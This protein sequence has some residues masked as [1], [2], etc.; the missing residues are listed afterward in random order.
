MAIGVTIKV[1]Q[2][3][4][5]AMAAHVGKT[6]D[7]IRKNVAGAI[8]DCA[9]RQKTNISSLI[10][11]NVNIKKKDVDEHIF[12]TRASPKQLSAQVTLAKTER[13]A[14]KDFG[15]R[16]TKKGVTYKI[17][18]SAAAMALMKSRGGSN[19]SGASR[20]VTDKKG[21]KRFTREPVVQE[22]V[23]GRIPNAFGPNIPRLG[24]N[25]FRRLLRG[26]LP[27]VKLHGPSAWGVF[28]RLGLRKQIKKDAQAY[29]NDRLQRR[30]L[31]QK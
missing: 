21:N 18:K 14:L 22:G 30:I 7:Q 12:V 4:L 28:T 6:A 5:N 16:Q 3:R 24:G 13:I 15:A 26:R 19:F 29:L 17:A 20:L 10:R 11:E 9:K 8:N 27:I 23:R 2:Q 25:V 1:D 31:Y